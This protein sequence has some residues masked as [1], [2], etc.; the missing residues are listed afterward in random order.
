MAPTRAAAVGSP[1][2][3]L[4]VEQQRSSRGETDS[5]PSSKLR[6]S[7]LQGGETI[8]LVQYAETESVTVSHSFV[9]FPSAKPIRH[10]STPKPEAVSTRAPQSSSRVTKPVATV[11]SKTNSSQ[12]SAHPETQRQLSELYTGIMESPASGET[13]VPPAHQKTAAAEASPEKMPARKRAREDDEWAQGGTTPTKKTLTDHPSA[14]AVPKALKADFVG[15]SKESFA[16][17]RRRGREQYLEAEI[18][19]LRREK[20]EAEQRAKK[21]EDKEDWLQV[22]LDESKRRNREAGKAKLEHEQCE[23]ELTNVKGRCAA[24]SEGWDKLRAEKVKLSEER[25]KLRD[26]KEKLEATDLQQK[27]ELES[28]KKENSELKSKLESAHE[29]IRKMKKHFETFKTGSSRAMKK[30][31]DKARTISKRICGLREEL[32][33]E[34]ASRDETMGIALTYRDE[35]TQAKTDRDQAR[36]DGAI[37]RQQLDLRNSFDQEMGEGEPEPA[38]STAHIDTGTFGRPSD[39]RE[40]DMPMSDAAAAAATTP[41]NNTGTFGRPSYLPQAAMSIANAAPAATTTTTITTPPV[42][43]GTF[44][45]P[46]YPSQADTPMSYVANKPTG[47]RNNNN[48]S[49]KSFRIERPNLSRQRLSNRWRNFKQQLNRVSRL[50]KPD[51]PMPDASKHT[52]TD[53]ETQFAGFAA[54]PPTGPR[55][56]GFSRGQQ[57]QQRSPANTQSQRDVA[58]TDDVKANVDHTDGGC[59]GFPPPAP[60][61]GPRSGGSGHD[62]RAQQRPSSHKL[63]ELDTPMTDATE[64]SSQSHKPLRSVPPSGP[65]VSEF[66]NRSGKEQENRSSRAAE[67]DKSMPDATGSGSRGNGTLLSSGTSGQA[68]QLG[69]E[70]RRI[71]DQRRVDNETKK[72]KQRLDNIAA[73]PTSSSTEGRWSRYRI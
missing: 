18:Y 52:I 41:R 49:R 68:P 64:S 12:R 61:S 5:D 60:P 8:D 10:I 32:E 24:L 43:T 11:N 59:F 27:Q 23:I 29:T 30:V 33:T 1:A 56:G 57:Q 35:G 48:N 15:A 13:S 46:S 51:T 14:I 54:P 39:F 73:T 25:D 65:R 37:V 31:K 2:R 45:R 40:V 7:H 26:E 71:E 20:D 28:A 66:G 62:G 69:V 53:P 17:K 72:L 34:K 22:K 6:D 63:P 4:K 67:L 9:G 55:G 19:Q 21:A 42:S 38:A 36:T 16:E 70:S 3:R 47:H 44:G 50:S 58:M